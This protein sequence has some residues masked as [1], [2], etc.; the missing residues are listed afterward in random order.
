MKSITGAHGFSGYTLL[1]LGRLLKSL[2]DFENPLQPL[3][4]RIKEIRE[5]VAQTD[6]V[7]SPRLCYRFKRVVT[8][9][10]I[11]ALKPLGVALFHMLKHLVEE[12]PRNAKVNKHNLRTL[13]GISLVRSG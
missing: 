5:Q 2:F 6:Q 13:G 11:V 12:S 8:R 10:N 3:N 1:D 7:V 9:K 4:V